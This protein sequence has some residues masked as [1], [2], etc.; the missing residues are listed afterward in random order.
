MR[1]PQI[2]VCSYVSYA[3]HPIEIPLIEAT[4]MLFTTKVEYI[5]EFKTGGCAVHEWLLA[6]LCGA[7]RIG[8]IAIILEFLSHLM[9]PFFVSLFRLSL[10]MAKYCFSLQLFTGGLLQ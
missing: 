1:L 6:V 3:I 8:L 10:Y 4:F 7:I 9:S 5:H 2:A